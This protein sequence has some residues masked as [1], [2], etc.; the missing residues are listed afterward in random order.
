MRNPKTGA[1]VNVPPKR[2]PFFKPSKEILAVLIRKTYGVCAG[3]GNRPL[4]HITARTENVA[5]TSAF[6]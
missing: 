5:V 3:A 4:L 6:T 1:R 2:I